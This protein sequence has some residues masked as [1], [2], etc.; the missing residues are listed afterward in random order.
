MPSKT[1]LRSRLSLTLALGAL[2]ATTL[3][4]GN[5][6]VSSGPLILVVYAL[7]IAWTTWLIR[8]ERIR[9]FLGRF[10]VGLG[11]FMISSLGLYVA[12]GLDPSSATISLMGHVWRIGALLATGAAINVAT[13][14][15]AEP[16]QPAATA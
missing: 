2:G 11:V 12:I 9:S 13:A 1:T 10:A 6:F 4:L 8:L 5:W 16:T 3:I 7:V 15:I 14:R